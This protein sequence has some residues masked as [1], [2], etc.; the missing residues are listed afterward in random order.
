MA[1]TKNVFHIPNLCDN[2]N[3]GNA[4]APIFPNKDKSCRAGSSVFWYLVKP[5]VIHHHHCFFTTTENCFVLSL[6]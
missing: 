6:C 4:I 3:P 5:E 2:M 1:F